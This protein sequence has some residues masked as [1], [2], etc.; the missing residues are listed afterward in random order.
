MSSL[1]LVKPEEG[2]EEEEEEEASEATVERERERERERPKNEHFTRPHRRRPRSRATD[3][4]PR[5]RVLPAG[6]LNDCFPHA[7]SPRLPGVETKKTDQ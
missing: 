7:A 5:K 4:R 1:S 6:S 3:H 2:G